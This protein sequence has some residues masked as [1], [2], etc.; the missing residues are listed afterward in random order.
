L[1]VIAHVA[2]GVTAAVSVGTTLKSIQL[3]IDD[4]KL[5]GMQ[6]DHSPADLDWNSESVRDGPHALYARATDSEGNEGKSTEV[7]IWVTNS[8]CGCSS[9]AGGWEVLGFIGLLTAIR[10]RARRSARRAAHVG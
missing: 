1:T 5:S 7:A 9:N 2:L 10:T 4:Q 8:S 3:Y 6:S